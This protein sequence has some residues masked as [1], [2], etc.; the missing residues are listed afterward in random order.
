LI[1]SRSFTDHNGKSSVN[2]FDISPFKVHDH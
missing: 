2:N 1:I